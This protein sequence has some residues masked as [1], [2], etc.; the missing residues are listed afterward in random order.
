MRDRSVPPFRFSARWRKTVYQP[1]RRLMP[2]EIDLCPVELPGRA[3]RVDMYWQLCKVSNRLWR[4][5]MWSKRQHYG[6]CRS[7]FAISPPVT[8]SKSGC[9]P[10]REALCGCDR[11][12]SQTVFDFIFK[13]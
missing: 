7:D 13:N 9:T 1:L 3:A 10:S 6:A 5:A 8:I 4:S 2:P 12:D 11:A